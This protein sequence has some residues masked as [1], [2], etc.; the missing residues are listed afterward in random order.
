MSRDLLFVFVVLIFLGVA[1]FFMVAQEAEEPPDHGMSEDGTVTTPGEPPV[2]EAEGDGPPPVD[3]PVP[4]PEEGADDGESGEPAE[5]G[6]E[7][8]G[9]PD[10]AQK[11]DV[12]FDEA[13][14][15]DLVSWLAQETG[16]RFETEGDLS[17]MV[18]S[19]NAEGLELKSLLDLMAAMCGLTWEKTDDGGIKIK[20]N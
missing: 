9:G 12:K 4:P 15:D 3:P 11:I 18:F 19:L 17:K 8:K 13:N 6:E 20:A 5:P 14:M 10:L 1:T 7:S 2:K 16:I